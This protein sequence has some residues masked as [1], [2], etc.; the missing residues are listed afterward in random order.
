MDVLVN[1]S[2]NK[3]C[4]YFDYSDFYRYKDDLDGAILSKNEVMLLVLNNHSPKYEK[5]LASDFVKRFGSEFIID[6]PEREK[7]GKIWIADCEIPRKEENQILG[8]LKEKY[9]L[10]NPRRIRMNDIKVEF[11]IPRAK[12]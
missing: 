10:D 3:D 9:L 8:Y 4:Y 7:E 6:P 5:F 11:A 12:K 1:F 2:I